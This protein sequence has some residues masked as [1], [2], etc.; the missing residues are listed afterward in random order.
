MA[1]P[2]SA[3]RELPKHSTPIRDYNDMQQAADSLA[4]ASASTS[5]G[6]LSDTALEGDYVGDL[7]DGPPLHRES[8]R[9][10]M[11]TTL[12]RGSHSYITV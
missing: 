7:D 8:N 12:L 6:G 10:S 3:Y 5:R 9:E 11:Y 4:F 2:R 1:V